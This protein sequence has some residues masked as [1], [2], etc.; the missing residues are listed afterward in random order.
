M[1]MHLFVDNQ[2][3]LVAA[4]PAPE[5]FSGTASPTKTPGPLY[6]GSSPGPDADGVQGYELE[7][8]ESLL[9]TSRDNFADALQTRL[10]EAIRTQRGL[11]PITILR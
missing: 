4:S 8:E 10:N 5:A 9:A 6:A 3:S 11:K 2:G 1:K 7:V